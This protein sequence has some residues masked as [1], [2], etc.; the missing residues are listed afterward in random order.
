MRRQR[1]PISDNGEQLL[2]ELIESV[3]LSTTPSFRPV[4]LRSVALQ[5]RQALAGYVFRNRLDTVLFH[6]EWVMGLLVVLAI[7]SF[8]ARS[9][10]DEWG[11]P[12]PAQAARAVAPQPVVAQ[13]PA[14]QPVAR[15]LPVVPI[16]KP[17]R[18]RMDAPAVAAWEILTPRD[19]GRARYP[20]LGRALPSSGSPA[21]TDRELDYISP[22]QRYPRSKPAKVAVAP[23]EDR[24]AAALDLPP[25]YLEAPAVGIQADAVEV[26]L[27][28]GT[29]QVADYAVGFL[30]GTGFPGAGNLVMA[31]HKGIRGA[32]FAN[33]EALQPGDEVFVDTAERRF[34]YKVRET[35]RVWPSE[36][37][38][39]YPT[40][41]P[42]LTLLTCTNWDLQRYVV[43]AEL[44]DSVPRVLS[45]GG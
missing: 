24:P 10:I 29:W 21:R 12:A 19:V 45:T 42:T 41:T 4:A 20:E 37:D 9:L 26:F 35:R 44:V 38:V 34:R 16:A 33:L 28:D 39:M 25:V 23:T 2:R 27:Q 13:P 6:A 43:V 11:H 1:A 40:S 17:T 30:H 22:S 14:R 15:S 5:R 18:P 36:V 8:A 3:Q 31:G 7:G 32:V